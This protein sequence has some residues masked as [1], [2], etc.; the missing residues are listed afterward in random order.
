MVVH[1]LEVN[2]DSFHLK[3]N[4]KELFGPKALYLI[5]INALIHLINYIRSYI[6]FM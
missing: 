6:S 4:N 2:K 1:L 5:T 3:E